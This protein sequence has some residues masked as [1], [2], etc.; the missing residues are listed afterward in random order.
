MDIELLFTEAATRGVLYKKDILK[1][2]TKF[3]VNKVKK[4]TLAQVFSCEFCEIFKNAF[5][6]EHLRA[7]ASVFIKR[8]K[9]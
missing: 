7:T 9:Y 4:E 2:F 6:T 3:T 8:S 5:F 1:N